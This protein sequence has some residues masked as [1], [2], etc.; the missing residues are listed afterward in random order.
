M[1]VGV[2]GGSGC[3]VGRGVRW[4]GVCGRSE[5]EVGLGVRWV[6]ILHVENG[7]QD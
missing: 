3:V 5:R 7:G 4:V 2:C 6:V 1:W